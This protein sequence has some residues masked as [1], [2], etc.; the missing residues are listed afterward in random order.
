M[1]DYSI[2]NES[3]IHYEEMGFK[4]IE[5]PWTVTEAISNITKPL[6][7]DDFIID[8]K[9]KVLVGSGEQSFLYLS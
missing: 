9:K 4:R 7:K 8:N 5:T 6:N 3:L 2:L 1:I